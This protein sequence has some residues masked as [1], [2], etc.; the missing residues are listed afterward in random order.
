MR[1]TDMKSQIHPKDAIGKTI[2]HVVL[3]SWPMRPPALFI[4]FTDG[5]F[6]S[7]EQHLFYGLKPHITDRLHERMP[8]SNQN[9][10]GVGLD[11]FA[12]EERTDG[13]AVRSAHANQGSETL[14]LYNDRAGRG[15]SDADA[16]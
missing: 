5:T 14:H 16:S 3:G 2:E 11:S 7:I 15:K 1:T 6:M 12:T 13:P 4:L 10:F 9:E 8:N